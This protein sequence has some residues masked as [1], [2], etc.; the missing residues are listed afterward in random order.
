VAVTQGAAVHSIENFPGFFNDNETLLLREADCPA[1]HRTIFDLGAW[2][3]YIHSE[4]IIHGDLHGGNLFYYGP[5]HKFTLIDLASSLDYWFLLRTKSPDEGRFEVDLT[6]LSP[7]IALVDLVAM[8]STISIASPEAVLPFVAGYSNASQRLIDPIIPGYTESLLRMVGGRIASPYGPLPFHSPTHEVFAAIEALDGAGIVTPRFRADLDV[9]AREFDAD[10]RT[11]I[12]IAKD[13]LCALEVEYRPLD[14]LY[15]RLHSAGDVV[16]RD[17]PDGEEPAAE[18]AKGPEE[19]RLLWSRQVRRSLLRRRDSTV[20][21]QQNSA[22]STIQLFEAINTIAAKISVSSRLAWL[23][24]IET[25]TEVL[26]HLLRLKSKTVALTNEERTFITS[27]YQVIGILFQM[28]LHCEDG[29]DME[30]QHLYVRQL[31]TLL[32]HRLD[33]DAGCWSACCKVSEL[34]VGGVACMNTE[35]FTETCVFR[36]SA[37]G[38]RLPN[39]LWSSAFEA[40]VI[41][42]NGAKHLLDRLRQHESDDTGIDGAL[43]VGKILFGNYA[44]LLQRM[45]IEAQIYTTAPYRGYWQKSGPGDMPSI[46]DEFD[47]ITQI[48]DAFAKGFD[49]DSDLASFY[50]TIMRIRGD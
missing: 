5:A 18:S 50:K 16:A 6:K 28:L 42:Q 24:F 31:A 46:W 48:A 9:L 49:L 26:V 11:A 14:E 25:T 27:T 7:D 15:G 33:G 37:E 19:V 1:E 45:L 23:E 8:H 30:R 40:R 29:P 4:G 17:R 10:E 44:T 39:P 43:Q 41:F 22:A 38:L 21:G 35:A 20:P 13:L 36:A 2:I 32:R 3:A 12:V 47:L 34:T